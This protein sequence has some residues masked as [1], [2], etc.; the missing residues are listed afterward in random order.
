MLGDMQGKRN[1]PR[2]SRS[3]TAKPPG[4]ELT[5]DRAFVLHL[6]ARAT[7]LRPRRAGRACHLR[8]EGDVTS[9][10]EL[11]A[12]LAQ[13]VRNRKRAGDR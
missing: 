2:S 12:F 7:A 3:T 5:P 4:L 6:D 1:L 10:R 11:V 9:V 13:A 8:P